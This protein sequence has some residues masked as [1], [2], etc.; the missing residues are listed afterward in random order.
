[1]PE[2][3]E[4]ETTV[5]GL[6]KIINIKINNIE[7]N[8]KKLRYTIPQ[9]SK[10]IIEKTT[11]KNVF[12]IGKYIIID[13]SNEY[14][15]IFHLGMSGRMKIIDKK[16]YFKAKHDHI[17]IQLYSKKNIIFNDSRKFGVFD[18]SKTK[19]LHKK[20]YFS[21]M[22]VDP[23][24]SDLNFDYMFK[25]IRKL[26]TSIKNILLNQSIISGVGNIYAC[27]ILFDAKISPFKKGIE[28]NKKEI[29]KLI[30]STKKIIKLAISKGGSTLKDY[31]STSGVL[32]NF[33][34]RE[35]MSRSFI[36]LG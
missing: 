20:K 19:L 30:K 23:L 21:K 36:W 2:L 4:V 11:I 27:E 29:I 24:T 14:S 13:L 31:Y 33:Q 22:G 15:I 17:I 25:K 9:N 12:R 34:K 7:I 18:Y 35:R 28:L 1:M 8:T 26:K 10:K 32:G 5:F 3:P 16:Y 6:K